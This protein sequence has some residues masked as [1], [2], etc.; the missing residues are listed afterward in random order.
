M[1][2]GYI[3]RKTFTAEFMSQFDEIHQQNFGTKAPIGGYPDDGNG[4][5]SRNISINEQSRV[6][7]LSPPYCQ[8]VACA[9]VC[10]HSGIA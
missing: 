6:N 2:Q 10:S 8:H 4:Y 1:A 7:S 3:R 5:Y 9:S